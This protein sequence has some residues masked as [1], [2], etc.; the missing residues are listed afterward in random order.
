MGWRDVLKGSF[1]HPSEFKEKEKLTHDFD[2]EVSEISEVLVGEKKQNYC[3]EC[4]KIIADCGYAAYGE[5]TVCWENDRPNCLLS[6]VAENLPAELI[7]L[8][9]LGIE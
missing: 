8:A 7:E 6:Y 1:H 9:K 2:I 5:I 4:G 3:A